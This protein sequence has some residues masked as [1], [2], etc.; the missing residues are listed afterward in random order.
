MRSCFA[1][2]KL[3]RSKNT[4]KS[5]RKK[6]NRYNYKMAMAT[7]II[8]VQCI[9]LVL[10]VSLPFAISADFLNASAVPFQPHT[11]AGFGSYLVMNL[12]V[13]YLQPLIAELNATSSLS[14]KSR[15]EAHI[16]V[17][18]PPE[19]NSGL[20]A[21]M[22]MDEINQIAVDSGI[23]SSKF[24]VACLARQSQVDLKLSKRSAVYNLIVESPALFAIRNR[25]QEKYMEKGGDPS[26]FDSE[27]YNPHITLAFEEHGD[28]FPEDQVFKTMRTCISKVKMVG[29][30]RC[31]SKH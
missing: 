25:I 21:V 29:R 17:I 12:N 10:S 1:S 22:T 6:E 2:R 8:L 31:S 4:T 30:K 26:N 7:M 19:F 27:R 23:Q 11:A 14:L 9:S 13:T 24:R 28:W 20:K 5:E 3:F 16:T 15:G 18:S